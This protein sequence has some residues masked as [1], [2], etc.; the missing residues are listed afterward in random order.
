MGKSDTPLLQ[1]SGS[2][3]EDQMFAWDSPPEIGD[4]STRGPAR[5][6]DASARNARFCPL[7]GPSPSSAIV[8]ASDQ[9]KLEFREPLGDYRGM[10]YAFLIPGAFGY[11]PVTVFNLAGIDV[12]D[13]FAAVFLAHPFRRTVVLDGLLVAPNH[14]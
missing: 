4:K 9:P 14:V 5:R 8:A 6:V 13:F 10:E 2:A 1:E 12:V 7:S 3:A 11:H